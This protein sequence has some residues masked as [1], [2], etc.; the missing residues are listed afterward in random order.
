MY[1]LG[2]GSLRWSMHFLLVTSASPSLAIYGSRR[3]TFLEIGKRIPRGI[4][5]S[6]RR[7][8]LPH[9]MEDECLKGALRMM[10]ELHRCHQPASQFQ[11]LLYDLEEAPNKHAQLNNMVEERL[12]RL[13]IVG[14]PS[15]ENW[16]TLTKLYAFTLEALR[17]RPVNPLGAFP[18][19]PDPEMFDINHW[20]D[21]DGNL[22]DI[23][24]FSFGFG[25][26]IC[27]G[28]NLANWLA[29]APLT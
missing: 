22:S 14:A 15:F 1:G 18:E 21:L 7:T 23:K 5:K 2:I 25:R 19:I 4:N 28:L 8:R 17:W 10:G 11:G 9:R 12:R 6:S 27:P 13:T 24:A 26:R 16:C 20:I 29:L 3:F